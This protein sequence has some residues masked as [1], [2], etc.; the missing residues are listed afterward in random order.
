[1]GNLLLSR[2][3]SD[4]EL[5]D[6]RELEKVCCQ[7]ENLNMKLNWDMLETR[8]ADEENDL[9][10]YDGNTLIGFLGLYC[11]G[12]KSR[13]I[14]ITGMVHPDN[15]R[16][17]LFKE[18][19][20]VARKECVAR[21]AE[22]ILLVCERASEE[23]ISFARFAGAQYSFSEYRMKFDEAAVPEFPSH[24]IR[25]RKAEHRDYSE[26][27]NL[28][29]LGF[30]LSEDKIENKNFD[31]V[32]NSMY[33]AELEGEVIGKIG[34]SLEGDSGYVFGFIIKPEYR[35]RGYGREVLSLAILKLLSEQVKA[36]LLEVEV[37]NENA[38][39][40]YKSCGFK[41]IT[42]YDYYEIIL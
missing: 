38:L 16:K 12:Q 3:L 27:L 13:E 26:L 25:L 7:Y 39:L 23:G 36:V 22:R 40:L 5:H 21:N 32:Y 17:G 34:M 11:I 19:F 33:L 9:L 31:D 4:N 28:D 24:G 15:R 20:N 42:V 2:G 30:G 10:Y 35:R 18:L 1:M 37:K 8:S 41:E 14:E 29:M 6:I